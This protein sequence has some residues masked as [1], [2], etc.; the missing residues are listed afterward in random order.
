MK[1]TT[2]AWV[3][4]CYL[5]RVSGGVHT[6]AEGFV[7][8]RLAVVTTHSGLLLDDPLL[9]GNVHHVQLDIQI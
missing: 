4:S 2:S 5:K 9:G 1:H 7:E 3:V 6:E 8:G